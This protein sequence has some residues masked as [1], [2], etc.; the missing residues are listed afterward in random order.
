LNHVPKW[1]TLGI[2]MNKMPVVSFYEKEPNEKLEVRIRAMPSWEDF[3]KLITFLKQEYN[4][5]VLDECDGPDARVWEL[6]SNGCRF[7]LIQ[8]DPYGNSLFAPTENSE[9][10]VIQI[11]KDLE[12]RLKEHCSA[13]LA[14]SLI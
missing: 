3:D 2:A 12:N 4:V 11:G 6:E 5:L 13:A 7:Q 1:V 10:L 9:A 14:P 8:D